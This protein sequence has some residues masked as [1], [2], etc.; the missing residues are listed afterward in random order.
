[1]IT[2]PINVNAILKYCFS[3]DIAQKKD[4]ATLGVLVAKLPSTTIYRQMS[5]QGHLFSIAAGRVEKKKLKLS[6]PPELTQCKMGIRKDVLRS[7]GGWRN[8][9]Y[10]TH[11]VLIAL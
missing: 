6:S 8:V 4:L 7:E 10:I 3:E 9:D 11:Q 5:L 2:L 1:M